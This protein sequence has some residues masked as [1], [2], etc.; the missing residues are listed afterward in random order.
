MKTILVVSRFPTTTRRSL[1]GDSSGQDLPTYFAKQESRDEALDKGFALLRADL[2]REFH[3]QIDEVNGEPGCSGTLGSAF[4]DKGSRVF[5][6]A[7][8]DMRPP[9]TIWTRMRIDSDADTRH[10]R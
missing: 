3:T 6:F 10:K 5:R 9:E 2:A 7:E 4:V 1:P 8:E